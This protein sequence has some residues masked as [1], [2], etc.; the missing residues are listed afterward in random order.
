MPRKNEARDAAIARGEKFYFTGQACLRGHVAK[1]YVSCFRC[2]ECFK[3]ELVEKR[4][5]TVERRATRTLSPREQAK[6]EGRTRYLTGKPCPR[7]HF[8]ER[9][10][11]NGACVQCSRDATKIREEENHELRDRRLTYRKDN[12]ERYRAHVRN[13]RAKA[14]GAGGSHSQRDVDAIWDKQL[15]RCAYCRRR[16]S[17]GYH[18]DHIKPISGGGDNSRRNLQLTCGPCNLRKGSKDPIAF[19]R[20]LGRLI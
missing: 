13:R 18:V 14:K 8:T 7:G 10:T 20:E 17:R 19:T 12:D 2:F 6:A 3:D 16:L 1:R 15:G 5:R 11:V 4:Q 9:L